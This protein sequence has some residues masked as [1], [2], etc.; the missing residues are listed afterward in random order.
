M[1]T[2]FRNL[3]F[4]VATGL[5]ALVSGSSARAEFN[6]LVFQDGALV[7]TF[8]DGG[9]GDLNTEAGEITADLTFLAA[10]NN[11]AFTG[12]SASSN[13]AEPLVAG[14][15]AELTQQVQFARAAGST[16]TS[17]LSIIATA[18]D[19]TFSGALTGSLLSTAS[20]SYANTAGT[21]TRSFQSFVDSSNT[22]ASVIPPG[23]TAGTPVNFTFGGTDSQ[24][25]TVVDPFGALVSPF[26]LS[27]LT[28][29]TLAEPTGT[30]G[31]NLPRDLSNGITQL[32]VVPEPASI[33]MLAAGLPLAALVSYRTRKARA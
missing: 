22:L 25:D 1:P 11:F 16:G 17:T 14:G 13:A 9:A 15:M 3:L 19:Y 27:S 32:N 21:D 12:L 8:V 29:V 23:G 33:L 2:R 31:N 26:T 24:Q 5:A 4:G 20:D 10:A 7:F 30:N 18:N 6:L 28:E